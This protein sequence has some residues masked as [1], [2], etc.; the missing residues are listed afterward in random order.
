MWEVKMAKVEFGLKLIES[1]RAWAQWL[2][3][4]DFA[5]IGAVAFLYRFNQDGLSS[6][7]KWVLLPFGISILAA[8]MVVGNLSSVV[9]RY[10]ASNIEERK[11]DAEEEN[12]S[13][14]IDQIKSMDINLGF[15]TI[16]GLPTPLWAISAVGGISFTIGALGL[17]FVTAFR[18]L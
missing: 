13:I 8:S 11:K 2:V 9:D 3:T 16:L 6:D 15:R 18:S 10:I 7:A 14:S 5:A 17:A 1:Y 4:L 12:I